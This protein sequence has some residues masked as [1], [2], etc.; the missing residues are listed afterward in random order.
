[1]PGARA[2]EARHTSQMNSGDVQ[3]SIYDDLRS[4]DRYLQKLQSNNEQ[5]FANNYFASK[6]TQHLLNHSLADKTISTHTLL[7]HMLLILNTL[8]N[9]SFTWVTG[10]IVLS[11]TWFEY[12]II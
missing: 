8:N 5:E 1:M 2:Q 10:F 12:L 6:R 9:K 4:E 11:K 3:P 7:Y